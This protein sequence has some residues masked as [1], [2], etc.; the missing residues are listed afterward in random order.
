MKLPTLLFDV[1]ATSMAG[2]FQIGY[3]GIYCRHLNKHHH[4]VVLLGMYTLS[5]ITSS[6]V[7]TDFRNRGLLTVDVH[8]FHS[9]LNICETDVSA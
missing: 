6:E 5:V 7:I 2:G 4:K 3:K 8:H 9:I 1:L